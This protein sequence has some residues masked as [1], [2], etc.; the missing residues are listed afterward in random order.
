[1]STNFDPYH[2]WL[3]IPQ[4]SRPLNH[5]QLLGLPLFTAE[6]P[7]IAEAAENQLAKIEPYLNG[8][9]AALARRTA[10]EIGQ[11]RTLLLNAAA[12]KNYDVQLRQSLGMPQAAVQAKKPAVPTTQAARPAAPA[13]PAGAQAMPVQ[14]APDSIEKSPCRA[15]K[16]AGMTPCGIK[17]QKRA[18]S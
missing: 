12:R 3:G 8:P 17:F 1:M 16:V 14:A 2:A 4:G 10:D 5:Y 6:P 15:S 9:P 13:A 18:M 7:V 11:A